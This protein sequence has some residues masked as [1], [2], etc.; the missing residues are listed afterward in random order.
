VAAGVENEINFSFTSLAAA[1]NQ[2]TMQSSAAGLVASRKVTM[3]DSAAV[4][5]LA[6]KV[7]GDVTTL[8]DWRSA[9][10]FGAV[11]GGLMGFFSLLRKH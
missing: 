11:V 10:A 7:E 1:G 3:K 6:N 2:A 8:F 9:V 5:V 4:L